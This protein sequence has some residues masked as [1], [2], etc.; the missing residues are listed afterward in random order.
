M[1]K[2][3]REF[4]ETAFVAF[5]V[6][7]L[8]ATIAGISESSN[9][10]DWVFDISFA[11]AL[12]AHVIYTTLKSWQYLGLWSV[13]LITTIAGAFFDGWMKFGIASIGGVAA[14]A[15]LWFS[16]SRKG[17]RGDRR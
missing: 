9:N 4:C 2:D 10:A 17:L 7:A 3:M 1:T 16:E 15:M 5:T 13:F 12:L 6:I 8:A 11:L 14:I